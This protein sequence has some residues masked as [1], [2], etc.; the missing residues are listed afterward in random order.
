MIELF[1]TFDI[2]YREVVLVFRLLHVLGPLMLGIA[3]DHLMFSVVLMAEAVE[4]LHVIIHAAQNLHQSTI[5][6][7]MGSTS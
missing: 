2:F 4:T 1:T 6:A 5:W 3:R 7:T